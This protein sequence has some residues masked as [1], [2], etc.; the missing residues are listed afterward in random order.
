MPRIGSWG[1]EAEEGRVGTWGKDTREEDE[2]DRVQLLQDGKSK[3]RYNKRAR[4]LHMS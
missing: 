1:G 4:T 3:R 2:D